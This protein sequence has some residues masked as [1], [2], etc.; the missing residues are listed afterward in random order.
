MR[1]LLVLLLLV[2]CHRRDV[3]PLTA[4]LLAIGAPSS[5]EQDAA[6]ATLADA[7]ARVETRL[8]AGA[9]P[10]EAF[11]AVVFDELHFER[12]V[13]EID[14][15][16]MRLTQVLADR[17]GSCL[18]LAALYLALG[19]RLGPAH[20]F[21]VNGVLVPGHFFVQVAGRNVE[22][23]RRGEE[24]PERWYRERYEVPEKDAPAYLR[25]LAPAEVL[26]VFDYNV[27]NDLRLHGRFVEAAIAYRRAIAA[28]P[29]L[30][31]AYASLGLV[32]HLT[33]ALKE[34]EEAYRAAYA[35]N[36]HLPGLEKN[37]AVL[38]EEMRTRPR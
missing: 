18:G 10:A 32:R 24:M 14:P 12:E 26:A 27:G 33:G 15:R 25:P 35:V 20:G 4:A 1:R 3:P 13:K 2:G 8:R 19:D 9:T 5:T 21:A 30:A 22:L 23:L 6:A 29:D 17:R 31:E 11:R 34:A 28:F 37:L 38:R 36:P 7:A 16:F